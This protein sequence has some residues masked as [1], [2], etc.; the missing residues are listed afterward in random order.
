[1]ENK[2]L[3]CL[4]VPV[5]C[6][7]AE[8]GGSGAFAVSYNEACGSRRTEPPS[9]GGTATWQPGSACRNCPKTGTQSCPC[10]L[11]EALV[12]GGFLPGSAPLTLVG[13]RFIFRASLGCQGREA[14]SV[15]VLAPELTNFCLHPEEGSHKVI[16]VHFC[17]S[18]IQHL[19]SKVYWKQGVATQAVS[20]G[21]NLGIFF[22]NSDTGLSMF[23]LYQGYLRTESFWSPPE[24]HVQSIFHW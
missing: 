3:L 10:K 16:S 19:F 5:L 15:W 20:G 21:G 14:G 24:G 6:C 4:P 11:R 7:T 1:M 12:C 9:P 13:H 17:L 22:H 18:T 2:L 8:A 23:T